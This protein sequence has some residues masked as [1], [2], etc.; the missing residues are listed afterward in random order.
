MR[1]E[2]SNSEIAISAQDFVFN[3]QIPL[4]NPNY[5]PA[6][7]GSGEALGNWNE[8]NVVLMKNFYPNFSIAIDS[9]HL[10]FP[11]EYKYV[12]YDTENKKI[13][14]WE[15][16]ENRKINSF[17]DEKTRNDGEFRHSKMWRGAGSAIPVFSLRTAES[18]G[19]G[20]FPD[21]IKFIDWAKMT[22]QRL[23]QLLPVSDTTKVFAN[24]DSYPY[25]QISVFALHPIY[26]NIEKMG[27]FKNK[28]VKLAYQKLK[29][30]LSNLP[31]VDYKRVIEEKFF[32][33]K[34]LYRKV[35]TTLWQ[36]KDFCEFVEKNK[37]WIFAYAGFCYLRD[38]YGTTDFTQWGEDK[39][40]YPANVEEMAGA[41]NRNK[42]QDADMYIYLQY[43]ADKQLGEASGYARSQGIV[44]KGD[45]PIGVNKHSVETWTNPTLF[46]LNGQAGAPPDDFS[47]IGQNWGFPTYN[48]DAHK[49][50]DFAWWKRRL[51]KMS[52][53]FDAYRIDHVLGLFRIW[54]I[55]DSAVW[56]LLGYFSPALPYSEAEIRKLG[57][58]FDKEKDTTPYITEKY[59]S[60]LFDDKADWVKKTF[61]QQ[62]TENRYAFN[63]KFDT[64]EK[65]QAFLKE[66]YPDQNNLLHNVLS[67][68]SEVLFIADPVKENHYH[69]RILIHSSAA[70]QRL[71]DDAKE[72]V[73]A[74]YN[75]FYFNRHNEF[76]KQEGLSKLPAIVASNEMLCCVEDLGMIP[77]CVPEVLKTLDVLTLDIER[78]PK[79]QGKEFDD[80][81]K[82]PYLS[83][84]TTSTHD[85]NPLRA[86]W[87]ED[88]ESSQRYF[89]DVLKVWGEAPFRCTAWICEQ[90]VQNHLLSPAMWTILPWQDWLAIDENLRSANPK[91]ERINVPSNP[92]HVWNYRMHLT[93]EEMLQ[94]SVL[95]KRITEMIKRTN[96]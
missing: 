30:E 49:K 40:Y 91:A 26:L 81:S 48:W 57:I 19:V 11:L 77:D 64:Q 89:N 9:R 36:D 33:F 28:K 6:I 83:V 10:N 52:E 74:L 90:I 51:T 58:F 2:K 37:D 35:K 62:T 46:N 22:G 54:E 27:E 59:L 1:R 63:A 32:F 61:L 34:Y 94:A 78:M 67:L 5:E 71:D 93:L 70:F 17:Y 55:P 41:K 39:Y 21:L 86:W 73:N 50:S 42:W 66:H 20:E 13:V 44:L 38:T 96:R 84:C 68:Y 72:K 8:R 75:D 47:V 95:N 14:E 45:L 23:V 29:S 43:H 18:F 15:T 92:H 53:Y 76:W 25:D 3:V 79:M 24:P 69:P 80:V 4:I 31:S 16:G 60:A 65:A 12:I 85:M 88:F 56:G 7:T 87:E 82:Y